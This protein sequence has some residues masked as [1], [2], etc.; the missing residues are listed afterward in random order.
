MKVEIVGVD[1]LVEGRFSE[2]ASPLRGC[3][4]ELKPCKWPFIIPKSFRETPKLGEH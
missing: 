3:T 4:V 1:I 2:F